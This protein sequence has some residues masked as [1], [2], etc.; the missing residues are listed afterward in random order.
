M[1]WYNWQT[2]YPAALEAAAKSHKPVMLQFERENCAGCRKTYAHV[3]PNR[4]VAAELYKNF[5]PLKLDIFK[6]RLIRNAQSAVWT[7]SFYF[8]DHREKTFFHFEG[9]VPPQEF[10]LLL[11]MALTY[12]YMPRGRYDEVIRT[13]EQG[14]ELFSAS[15]RA[16][17]LL[18]RK[19]IALF[20]KHKDKLAF[21]ETMEQIRKDYPNS[22]EALMW[23]WEEEI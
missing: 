13:V 8:L 10:R 3:Y 4:D 2:S 20:L 7:P 17:A 18:F 5:I 12:Y 11:R 16:A 9:Y 1:D 21:V 19:G 22:A 14:M 6:E 15:P 23:P